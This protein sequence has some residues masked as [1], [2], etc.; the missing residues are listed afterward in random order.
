MVAF[1]AVTLMRLPFESLIIPRTQQRR[2]LSGFRGALVGEAG[3][4]TDA[5]EKRPVVKGNALSVRLRKLF[6]YFK[7][8]SET[9]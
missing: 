3:S 5:A 8:G 1:V 9:V 6:E 4:E 7:E 2:E